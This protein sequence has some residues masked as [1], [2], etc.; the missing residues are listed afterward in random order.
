MMRLGEN[1]TLGKWKQFPPFFFSIKAVVKN[2][3]SGK[4]LKILG[5]KSRKKM[6][7][8]RELLLLQSS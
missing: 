1:I 6:G 4:P 7:F 5:E 2:M 3:K 8:V